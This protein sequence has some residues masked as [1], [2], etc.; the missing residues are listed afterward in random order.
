MPG[1]SVIVRIFPSFLLAVHYAKTL[2]F[3]DEREKRAFL[4]ILCFQIGNQ[5]LEIS[6][7]S[8]AFFFLQSFEYQFIDSLKGLMAGVDVGLSFFRDENGHPDG[9]DRRNAGG[10][11]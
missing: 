10:S 5:P 6:G 3:I 8:F 9:E 7:K 4:K 1:F 11:P 2:F